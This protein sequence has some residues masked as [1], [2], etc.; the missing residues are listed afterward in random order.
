MGQ[1]QISQRKTQETLHSIFTPTV[2]KVCRELKNQQVK[3]APTPAVIPKPA[4]SARLLS[5]SQATTWCTSSVPSPPTLHDNVAFAFRANFV[6]PNQ[7]HWIVESVAPYTM[8]CNPESFSPLASPIRVVLSDNSTILATGVCQIPVRMRT[9]GHAVLQYAL[10]VPEL[11]GKLLSVAYHTHRGADVGFSGEICQ[12]FV[13][14]LHSG[15]K[16]EAAGRLWLPPTRICPLVAR[17]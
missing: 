13:H 5:P 1:R 7:R 12:I 17:A 16:L 2:V 10:F 4:A 11:N 9:N 6:K 8:N 14:A 15:Q 3:G